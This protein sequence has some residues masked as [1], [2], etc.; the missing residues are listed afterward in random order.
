[1]PTISHNKN[2]HV[3]YAYCT[4][5]GPQAACYGAM[6]IHPRRTG[7][8]AHTRF[9]QCD[10]HVGDGGDLTGNLYTVRRV[11]IPTD[12]ISAFVPT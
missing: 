7:G 8:I 5:F 11:V 12:V 2:V 9:R 6:C 3:K 10:V 1:M 4:R